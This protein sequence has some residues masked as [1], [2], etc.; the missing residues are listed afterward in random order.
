MDIALLRQFCAD[1]IGAASGS[2]RERSIGIDHSPERGGIPAAYCEQMIL[3][4]NR[5]ASICA[6]SFCESLSQDDNVQTLSSGHVVQFPDNHLLTRNQHP[7][8]SS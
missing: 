2:P 4:G 3:N 8:S 7:L 6:V 1:V 5:A